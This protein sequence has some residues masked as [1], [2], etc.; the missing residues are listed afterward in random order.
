MP[1][2]LP[3]EPT[4]A[5]KT[6]RKIGGSLILFI[7]SAILLLGVQGI[8]LY[9]RFARSTEVGLDN[10][11][12][13]FAQLE[14][15][16]KNFSL[17]LLEGMVAAGQQALDPA[18]ERSIRSSFDIYYSRTRTVSAV[19]N[20]IFVDPAVLE[21][22]QRLIA[23]SQAIANRLDARP[24]LS[25]ADLRA[26][27][28][29][30]SM[31]MPNIRKV[32]NS[33]LLD[34]IFI[35]EST[36]ETR[37]WI[38]GQLQ[39]LLGLVILLMVA[40]VR[41]AMKV[42]RSVGHHAAETA[43]VAARLRRTLNASLDAVLI[44]DAAG[45]ITE[46]NSA[47]RTILGNPSSE[48]IIGQTAVDFLAHEDRK[49]V[50]KLVAELR[51][52]APLATT[53]IGT[54]RRINV[55]LL[56]AGGALRPVELSCA[57]DQSRA[58]CFTFIVC[59]RDRSQEVAAADV[60]RNARDQARL[61]AKAKE[62]FLSVLSHE[63]RTP[64]HGVI[65]SLELVR[66]TELKAD[67]QG[68]LQ[69]AAACARSA[70]TQI[71]DVLALTRNGYLGDP[72][73]P[74]VP[75]VLIDEIVSE[76]MP[77]ALERG[78][79]IACDV[80]GDAKAD[81]ILAKH[82]SFKLTV[83][84]L[85]SNAVKYTSNGRID[86]SLVARTKDD[87]AISVEVSVKDTGLGIDP[88]DHARIFDEFAMVAEQG[89]DRK[90]GFG[91]GLAIAKSSVER[92]N[93]HIG[94]DSSPGLGSTFHFAFNAPKAPQ[95]PTLPVPDSLGQDEPDPFGQP[96]QIMIVDDNPVNR[97]LLCEMIKRLGHVAHVAQD[98][99]TAFTLACERPYDLILMDISMPGLN[100]FDAARIIRSDSQ[101]RA[102]R[103]VALSAR[104]LVE[105][106]DDLRDAGI[107]G[108]FQK[109]IGMSQLHRLLTEVAPQSEVPPPSSAVPV[110]DG[111]QDVRDLL[112]AEMTSRL[113][114]AMLQDATL[115]IQALCA[116]VPDLTRASDLGDL[117]HRASGSAAVLGAARLA[118]LWRS[119]ET[120]VTSND[121]QALCKLAAKAP[122]VYGET[123]AALQR[124]SLPGAEHP[125]AQDSDPGESRPSPDTVKPDR[126]RPDPGMTPGT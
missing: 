49:A 71:D 99:T 118:E 117:A 48:T 33:A 19:A 78:N 113:E 97:A 92:L 36:R 35:A 93:G 4:T 53:E 106:A 41:Q 101:N 42:S 39:L 29:D 123:V 11:V 83:R 12:W 69:T 43:K 17:A 3:A 54:A 57:V 60:L 88:Q 50:L 84:N 22:F 68:F 40:S 91:L 15:E 38:V 126:V 61:D 59:I 13:L 121:Q 67:E 18:V 55:N 6:H 73:E 110:L 82:R 90:T 72:D 24:T 109:P 30:F 56:L 63:M 32:A 108:A 96:L 81:A 45:K 21:R 1:T 62:R 74:F 75:M 76:I 9:D 89:A 58:R 44:V 86:V 34:S 47:L 64:L 124:H 37:H 20:G 77:L 27:H 14:V 79:S 120:S 23:S 103:I 16:A 10:Q 125:S 87:G 122:V 94:I 28:A 2:S 65:T 66:M 114:G 105:C 95:K 5:H 115:A 26:L 112:G 80:S 51:S 107:D 7:L 31:D 116:A 100:G 52:T 98:G 70:L 104:D 102:T 8:T 119:V 25:V 85:I 111:F 46:H